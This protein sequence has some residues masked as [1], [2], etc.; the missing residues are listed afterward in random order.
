MVCRRTST[1]IW[2]DSVSRK[3]PKKSSVIGHGQSSAPLP[4]PATAGA[5]RMTAIAASGA[6]ISQAMF[7]GRRA[8]GGR[9]TG[10]Y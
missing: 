4:R 9:D 7:S 3:S 1:W 10:S 2:V 8:P 6:V 5:T